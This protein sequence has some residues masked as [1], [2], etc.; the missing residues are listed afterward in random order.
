MSKQIVPME[1]SDIFEK[2]FTLIGKTFFRNLIIALLFLGLPL[3]LMAIA[4]DDFSSS[5]ADL[6]E[7]IKNAHGESIFDVFISMLETLSFFG[8]ASLLLMLG[9]LLAEIAISVVVSEELMSYSISVTDAIDETFSGR[10]LHGIGQALLKIAIVAGAAIIVIIAAV[11]LAVVSK[12]LMVLF[13]LICRRRGRYDRCRIVKRKL[14]SGNRIL[15]E[16]LRYPVFILADHAVGHHDCITADHIR[17]HVGCLQ[18]IFYDSG[19]NRRQN[20]SG[21]YEKP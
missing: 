6:Q 15:V 10:W 16:N 21:D 8:A 12:L 18:R 7:T 20:R 3:I 4:A 9:S 2:T 19:K 13:V 11:M 14:G 5:I 1:L 17:Q